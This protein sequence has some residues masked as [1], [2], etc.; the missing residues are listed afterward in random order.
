MARMHSGA[1]GKSGSLKPEDKTKPTW[2]RYSEKEIEM[3]ILKLAKEG[4]RGSRIG[5]YLRDSYGIPDV[6]AIIGKSVS[7]VLKE[8]GLEGKVPE[9][10]RNLLER[11]VALQKHLAVNKQDKTA[12]RGLQLTESKVRRLMKYYKKNRV[13]P[14]DWKYDPANIRLYLE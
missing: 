12:K 5:A 2:I 6:K 8:K 3:L 14:A 7:A 4:L 1:K 13:L 11:I 9:D 10:L